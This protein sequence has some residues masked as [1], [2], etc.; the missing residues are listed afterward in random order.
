M[1]DVI[2]YKAIVTGGKG[3]IGSHLV[4]RLRDLNWTIRIL[5]DGCW[6]ER[7]TDLFTDSATASLIEFKPDFVFH[8]G[9]YSRVVPSF[10]N[11]LATFENNCLGTA[12]VLEFC[13]LTK[14]K[15]IYAG[16]STKFAL[17]GLTHS[18]YAFTKAMNTEHIKAYAQW[19]DLNYAICYFYNV[20]GPR[21]NVS[22]QP[23]YESVITCF[24]TLFKENKPLTICGT[25]NQQRH[26]TYVLD[27]IDGLIKAALANPNIEIHLC[28]PKLYSILEI[29]QRFNTS[30]VHLPERPG[31]RKSSTV[32]STTTE[33][34]WKPTLS[35]MEYIDSIIL[36]QSEKNTII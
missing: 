13:K 3:F 29:A 7:T 16:S 21:L 15:L 12:K 10:D 36:N 28:N 25:G 14:A 9:E 4:Q 19:F 33:I 8:L 30:I 31:D 26:F 1:P 24:E 17:E 27:I 18:P 20:F 5:D 6:T 11:P 35:V 22:K 32:P 23:T 2:T 34:N